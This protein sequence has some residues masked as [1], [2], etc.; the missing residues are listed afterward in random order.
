MRTDIAYGLM[1]QAL[2]TNPL[3]ISSALVGFIIMAIIADLG[4]RAVVIN[5]G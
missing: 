5:K 1:V 4:L 3:A 2:T